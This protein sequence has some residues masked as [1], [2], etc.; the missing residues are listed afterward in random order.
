ME[1]DCLKEHSSFSAIDK[2]FVSDE[3]LTISILNSQSLSKRAVDLVN[4][5]TDT[6]IKQSYST[7]LINEIL[8]NFSMNCN[9]H[10]NKFLS[11]AYGCH[12]YIFIMKNFRIN[13]ISRFNF[14]K[15]FF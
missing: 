12:D 11:L 4:E 10:D 1:Y 8:Y 15:Y 5:F 7:D 14:R 9:D 2:N 3:T 6:Q 13:G